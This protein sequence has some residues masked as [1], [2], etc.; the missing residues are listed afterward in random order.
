MLSA[1]VDRLSPGVCVRAKLGTAQD[2]LVCLWSPIS[3]DSQEMQTGQKDVNFITIDWTLRRSSIQVHTIFGNSICNKLTK[4]LSMLFLSPSGWI[5][6][7]GDLILVTH[8]L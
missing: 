7:G 5:Q 8:W 1:D 6:F 4:A 2:E 3:V